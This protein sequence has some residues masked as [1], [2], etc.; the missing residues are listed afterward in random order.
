VFIYPYLSGHKKNCENNLGE[1]H[2]RQCFQE[3]SILD[4]IGKLAI[5]LSERTLDM[6]M[7]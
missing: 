6:D 7:S 5:E 4:P 2:T 1:E 3:I